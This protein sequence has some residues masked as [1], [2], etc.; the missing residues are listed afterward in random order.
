MSGATNMKETKKKD[1]EPY[2]HYQP[3][4]YP[5]LCKDID[6]ALKPYREAKK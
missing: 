2:Q 4:Q 6:R 5:N 3:N 1:K